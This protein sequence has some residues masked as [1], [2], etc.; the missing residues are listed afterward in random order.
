M[1]FGTY[2]ANYEYIFAPHHGIVVRYEYESIPETYTDANI[3]S[4]GMAFVLNYRLLSKKDLRSPYLGAFSRYRIYNGNGS[5][6]SE[7]FEF[8]RKDVTI[9]LN[10]G[11]R[12][13]WKN[14]FNISLMFGYGYSIIDRDAHP[15]SDAI[16]VSIDHF[17]N[18]YDFLGSFLGEFSIGYAF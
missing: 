9:G 1:V 7:D 6:E 16:E 8:T 4:S 18:D 10:A 5:I 15:S 12:W 3:E 17:E 13:I 2:A 11:K 14:G